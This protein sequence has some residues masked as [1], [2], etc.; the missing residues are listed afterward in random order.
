MSLAGWPQWK[1][2]NLDPSI[3]PSRERREEFPPPAAVMFPVAGSGVRL[4]GAPKPAATSPASQE[5]LRAGTQ[6]LGGSTR[7]LV[8]WSPPAPGIHVTS[9]QLP[10]Q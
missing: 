4:W 2:T 7:T 3:D 8:P 6:P 5:L 9:K 1:L 10:R